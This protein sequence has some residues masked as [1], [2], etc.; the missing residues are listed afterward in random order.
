MVKGKSL[1]YEVRYP[2]GKDQ[3]YKV[4]IEGKETWV[5]RND[6]PERRE[7]EKKR[8]NSLERFLSKA[9]TS[10]STRNG[11]WRRR[12]KYL[13]GENEFLENKTHDKIKAHYNE[14]I[15]IYGNR[16]PIT[17]IKFTT[18]RDYERARE[19]NEKLQKRHFF[20][21]ISTDRLLNNI[22]YT[23]QNTLFTS[24][25][26]NMARGELKIKEFKYIFKD[27]IIERYKKI[28]IERFP[29]QK[30]ALQA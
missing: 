27:E 15:E 3:H 11:V 22:N 20:S 7:Y 24:T 9:K 29:D 10:M 2:K 18:F 4:N 12:G 21:N 30:Y 25:G 5:T 14:Q 6:L 17:L 19:K 23:K 16:C 13:L 26:W 8:E 1:G 28:L